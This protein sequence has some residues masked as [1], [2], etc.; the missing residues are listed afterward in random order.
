MNKA[1]HLLEMTGTKRQHKTGMPGP[2]PP[3]FGRESTGV[4]FGFN[5]STARC[6]DPRAV[7]QVPFSDQVSWLETGCFFGDEQMGR[8]HLHFTT[9]QRANK[10][11]EVCMHQLAKVVF[12]SLGQSHT[13]ATK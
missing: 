13:P 5:V 3:L 4:V 10:Q 9:E 1:P 12:V 8:D 11:R 6:F 7:W 2:L